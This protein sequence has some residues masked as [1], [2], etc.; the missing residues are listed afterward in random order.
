MEEPISDNP[1]TFNGATDHLSEK[2]LDVLKTLGEKLINSLSC[3]I[4]GYGVPCHTDR[5]ESIRL[6]KEY[7]Q[8]HNIKVIES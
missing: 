2:E 7:L 3:D 6:M 8:I 5:F 4:N 1:T